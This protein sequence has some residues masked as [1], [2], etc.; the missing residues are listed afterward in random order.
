LSLENKA[1]SFFE[2][3]RR[4]MQVCDMIIVVQGVPGERLLLPRLRVHHDAPQHPGSCALTHTPALISFDQLGLHSN[5]TYVMFYLDLKHF[6][7]SVIRRHY[8]VKYIKIN[9]VPN[10]I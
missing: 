1:F 8:L 2:S 5:L 10:T 3:F 6:W 7:M 9:Y 4:D